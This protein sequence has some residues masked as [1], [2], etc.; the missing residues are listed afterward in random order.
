MLDANQ[1][2]LGA[3]DKSSGLAH[4]TCEGWNSSQIT[5]AAFEASGKGT[6]RAAARVHALTQAGE[7]LSISLGPALRGPCKVRHT[8]AWY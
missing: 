1:Q 5:A 6:N 8:T 3:P 2:V 4:L 7:M